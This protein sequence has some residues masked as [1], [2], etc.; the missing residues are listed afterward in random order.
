MK[1]QTDRHAL[2]VRVAGSIVDVSANTWLFKNNTPPMR[3][4]VFVQLVPTRKTHNTVNQ[5]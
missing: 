3:G 4:K 5:N 1:Y 2:S